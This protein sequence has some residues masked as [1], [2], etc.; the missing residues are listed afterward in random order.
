IFGGIWSWLLEVSAGAVCCV[1][2][3]NWVR[4]SSCG[5]SSSRFIMPRSVS[6]L[7]VAEIHILQRLL[8]LHRLDEGDRFLQVV[9]L[10]AGDA[11]FVA[12]DR[13]LDLELAVLQLLD[14]LLGKRLLDT[15]L[16]DHLLALGAMGGLLRVLE[17][18]GAGIELAAGDIDLQ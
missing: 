16:D 15:L 13:D 3:R 4:K 1:P 11:Q 2:A 10:L 6:I 17:F 9:A 5:G 7:S 12:L 18:Q 14:D 8:D